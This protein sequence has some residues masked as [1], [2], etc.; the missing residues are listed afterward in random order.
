MF[1][2]KKLKKENICEYLLYMW[3]IEDLIRAFHLNIDTINEKII[4]TYPLKDETERKSLY[5]WYESL[6]DMMRLENIQEQGH[7]QLNKNIIIELNDFH[8]LVL[9]SG[10]VPSYNAKF[11]HVLPFVNQLHTKTE[12]N[13]GDI[14]LCFNFMYGIMVLRMKK[15]EISPET[16]QSQTEISK[17]LVLLARNYQL[18]KNGELDLEP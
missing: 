9:K 2:A 15:I 8:S 12:S 13:L 18:Y 7:L 14:E 6:I 1:I 5:E 16:L 11:F 10:Q 17:F 3:Q 4:A